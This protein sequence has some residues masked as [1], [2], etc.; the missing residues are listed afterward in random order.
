MRRMMADIRGAM[1]LFAQPV[2][3]GQRHVITTQYLYPSGEYVS[4][5][6]TPGMSGNLIVTD[7]GGALD[8]LSAHGI[9]IEDQKRA[10]AVLRRFQ[11][12]KAEG[13]EI[14]AVK[15]PRDTELLSHAVV[16]VARASAAVAEY[17]M[18]EFKPRQKR[19]EVLARLLATPPQPKSLS[20]ARR[21]S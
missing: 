8:T 15:L 4:V 2:T 5:Y 1:R 6:V 10:F 18:A 21:N 3:D 9:H 14:R 17:C 7:G 11:G 20:R 19:D 12:V 16:T 13:G